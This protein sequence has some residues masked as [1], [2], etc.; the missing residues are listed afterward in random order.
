MENRN[1]IIVLEDDVIVARNQKVMLG[2]FFPEHEINVFH[3]G[4]EVISFCEQMLLSGRIGEIYG[5][6]SDFQLPGMDG[7]SAMKEINGLL[8]RTPAVCSK[9]IIAFVS[10]DAESVRERIAEDQASW[11]RS[12]GVFNKP[13]TRALIPE[14]FSVSDSMPMPEVA[15]TSA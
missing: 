15:Q 4:E 8:E 12:A 3:S 10:S 13:F 5:I 9:P 6:V 11:L 7:I 1:H 2:Y 14:I